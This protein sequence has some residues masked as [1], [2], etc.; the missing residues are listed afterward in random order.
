MLA[1][2]VWV[3]YER[4]VKLIGSQVELIR[5]NHV[6]DFAPRQDADFHQVTIDRHIGRQDQRA[7]VRGALS[8]G[9]GG[10][11]DIHFSIT[12]EK[13][14]VTAEAPE[15]L[16]L[17]NVSVVSI[18]ETAMTYNQIKNR[19]TVAIGVI[20]IS[21]E[22]IEDVS[23]I[24]LTPGK[25]TIAIVI[26]FTTRISQRLEF[27]PFGVMNKSEI[28]IGIAPWLVE[29]FTNVLQAPPEPILEM[30]LFV[31]APFTLNQFAIAHRTDAFPERR[32]YRG[33]RVTSFRHP[34][35]RHATL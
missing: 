32:R 30:E 19:I 27:V 6:L 12:D 14:T 21:S 4:R 2:G 20:W 33:Q 10:R 9:K 8:K 34:V 26:C 31:V 25:L 5:D 23:S 13:I 24:V 16:V 1:T 22:D 35:F 17:M 15:A 7:T 29:V 11:C 18:Q 3:T 28:R